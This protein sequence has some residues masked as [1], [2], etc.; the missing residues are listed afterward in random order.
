MTKARILAD[1]VSSDDE[2]ALKAPLASPTFTGTPIAPA[3]KLTP[4]DTEPASETGTIYYD[5]SEKRIKHYNGSIWEEVNMN[6]NYDRPGDGPY[7]SDGYTVLLI[8]SNT[9][10]GSTTFVDSGANS[11]TITLVGSRL[12]HDSNQQKIGTT[13]MFFNNNST[14][15]D[16]W[17]SIPDH[18]DW[19]FGTGDFTID[20][21]IRPKSYGAGGYGGLISFT[22]ISNSSHNTRNVRF[23]GTGGEM[24]WEGTNNYT[25]TGTITLDVWTHIAITRTSAGVVKWYKNGIL[26]STHTGATTDFSS[27]D[28][29]IITIGSSWNGYTSNHGWYGY[30]DELR[31]SK[32]I[33]RWTDN[34]TVY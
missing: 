23:D 11:H 8:H 27:L 22:N 14:P 7:D 19:D 1:Y 28:G 13:S 15:I 25:M 26:D 4:T 24:H 10:H 32:G 31:I 18:A 34:F 5:N 17:L 3:L 9:S 21:W 29:E 33:V 6:K 16:S 30:V 12:D 2:L 20:A